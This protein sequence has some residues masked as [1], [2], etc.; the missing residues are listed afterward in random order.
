MNNT[1]TVS[2]TYTIGGNLTVNRIGYGAM[3]LSGQ[4]GNFAMRPRV[5][6]SG[7]L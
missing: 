5:M 3:R 6:R 2:E 1:I 7:I 4:P